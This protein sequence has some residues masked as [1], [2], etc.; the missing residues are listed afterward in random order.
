MSVSSRK[1]GY[2]GID[3]ECGDTRSFDVDLFKRL[4]TYIKGLSGQDR[5]IKDEKNNKAMDIES[6]EFGQRYGKEYAEIVF[7][8]C[9]YNHSPKYM[10]SIDG[11]ER[12]TDKKL[13]EGEK[14]I[15]HM[16]MRFD[17]KEAF[18]LFEERRSGVT[19]QSVIVFLNRNLCQL[20][21]IEN[22]ERD[23]LISCGRMPSD[24]F[25]TS[26]EHTSRIVT[27][28]LYTDRTLV[29]SECM[30]LMEPDDSIRED[31]VVTVK[32]K[33]RGTLIK[34]S[35]KN[36]YNSFTSHGSKVNRIR[37]YTKDLGN[38]DMI[39]DTDSIRKIKEINVKL[40]DDGVVDTKSIFSKMEEMIEVGL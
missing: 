37:L 5:I 1:I 35:L 23:L 40:K 4:L 7:K 22:D 11:S 15:T 28:E 25:L 14:E 16:C 39:I 18:T 29:G 27:A 8:S 10:S 36:L 12:D 9:K 19:M 38:K 24:D 32:A 13:T 30:G 17:K 6:I 33:E 20:L 21:E 2:F 3:F 31:I 26:L 34:N